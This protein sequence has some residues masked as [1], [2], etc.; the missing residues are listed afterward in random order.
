[1]LMLAETFP[2]QTASAIALDGPADFFARDDA[3]FRRG[4]F[5]Q[6]MPIRDEAAEREALALLADA[7]EIAALRQ[8]RRAAQTQAFRRRGVH[9]IKPA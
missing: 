7:G 4:T 8:A 1:M 9:A 5:G 2:Q 3:E 6:R